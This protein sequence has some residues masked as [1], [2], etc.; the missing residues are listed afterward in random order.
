M[1]DARVHHDEGSTMKLRLVLG[2]SAAMIVAMAVLCSDAGAVVIYDN[3]AN[4]GN[5]F[6]QM[7]QN[8]WDAQRF[9]SD[10]TNLLLTS[11]TLSFGAN[12]TTGQY[13]LSLYNDVAN[14]P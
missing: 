6:F 4:E 7:H 14:H 2:I 1:T 9:N 10:S 12:P 13:R 3:L 5:G 11:A 8:S